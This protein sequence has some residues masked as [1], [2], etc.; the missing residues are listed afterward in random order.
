MKGKI[1]RFGGKHITGFLVSDCQVELQKM[2]K[3]K[4]PIYFVA[5][6]RKDLSERARGCA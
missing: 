1:S 6:G 4:N 3:F 5:R 2:T